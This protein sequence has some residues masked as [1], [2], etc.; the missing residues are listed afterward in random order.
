MPRTWR[1]RRR[2]DSDDLPSGLRGRPAQALAAL[3]VAAVAMLVLSLWVN[4]ADGP[5]RWDVLAHAAAIHHRED[6]VTA[7]A[8]ALTASTETLAYVF[9]ALGGA[10]LWRQRAWLGA[11][12]SVLVLQIGA[13]GRME[14]SVILGRPRPPAADWAWSAGGY[15]F[16]SGHTTSATIAAGL[17]AIGV[18]R[19]CSG[20][21]RWVGPSLCA[22]WALAIGWTRVYLGMHWLT[23]V[24]GGWLLGGVITLLVALGVRA[25]DA[26]APRLTGPRG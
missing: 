21:A 2:R 18:A 12:I 13:A 6:E 22:G 14:L 8:I 9:A 16:P 24:L 5:L 7:T 10:L 11:L 20:T 15:A 4:A 3:A 23:D 1:D 25:A 19:G 17:L 26:T